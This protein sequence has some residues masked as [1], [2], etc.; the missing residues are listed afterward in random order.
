MPELEVDETALVPDL[1]ELPIVVDADVDGGDIDVSVRV[2]SPEN[3][4]EAYVDAAANAISDAIEA[5]ITPE[6]VLPDA[7]PRVTDPIADDTLDTNVTIRVLSPGR[8]GSVEQQSRLGEDDAAGRTPDLAPAEGAEAEGAEPANP[9]DGLAETAESAPQYQADNMQYQSDG[10]PTPDPWVWEWY[11]AL[12]C[13]GNVTST[14]SE[15]GN[16]DSRDWDWKWT[17]DWTCGLDGAS[18][19]SGDALQKGLASVASVTLPEREADAPAREADAPAREAGAAP[20]ATGE[21]PDASGGTPW[22]W[23]WSFDFCGRETTFAIQAGEQTNLGWTWDWT[24]AW[25]C[26]SAEV[27]APE[28]SGEGASG[29]A[30]GAGTP[31][32]ELGL[33]PPLAI[34]IEQPLLHQVPLGAVRAVGSHRAHGCRGADIDSGCRDA[35]IDS[36]GD[37]ARPHCCYRPRASS[38]LGAGP[39]GACA[40]ARNG[41]V[42]YRS[43]HA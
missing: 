22:L 4:P 23:T 18:E 6:S 1:E 19:E 2:L 9:A 5:D 40:G 17:W 37:T 28:S 39:G 20:V 16:P 35:D 42:C 29:A 13:S 38:R 10:I 8:N 27:V 33:P 26:T 21:Q 43:V 12:D 3:E 7:P 15:H 24:W 34:M 41:P 36:A 32:G 11:L 31:S 25:A 14:S 30:A